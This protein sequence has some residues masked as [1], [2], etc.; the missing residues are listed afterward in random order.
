M[1]TLW[2]QKPHGNIDVSHDNLILHFIQTFFV[3]FQL[4]YQIVPASLYVCVEIAYWSVVTYYSGFFFNPFSLRMILSVL[5]NNPST[6][7]FGTQEYWMSSAILRCFLYWLRVRHIL[8]DKTG[9]ITENNLCVVEFCTRETSYGM[10]SSVS[11]SLPSVKPLLLNM[12]LNHSA[13]SIT[14]P[15]VHDSNAFLDC[16]S[17]GQSRSFSKCESSILKIEPS[18]SKSFSEI[19]ICSF[20]EELRM[21]EMSLLPSKS[22]D[23]N[24]QVFCSSQDERVSIAWDGLLARQYWTQRLDSAIISPLALH[25]Q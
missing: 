4:C 20:D 15:S 23:S 7:T 17:V 10:D 21:Q 24:T 8:S 16:L 6:F 3:Y 2:D 22:C 11:S 18:F 12:I 13:L 9:T 19:R 14:N 25:I 5:T 1:S